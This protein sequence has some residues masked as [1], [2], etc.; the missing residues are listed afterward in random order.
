MHASEFRAHMDNLAELGYTEPASPPNSGGIM[1]AQI[2]PA[3]LS[4][5]QILQTQGR[6]QAEHLVRVLLS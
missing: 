2:M 6:R 4:L 3:A 1:E 5:S